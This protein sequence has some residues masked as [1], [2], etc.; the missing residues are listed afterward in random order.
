MTSRWEIIIPDLD[1]DEFVTMLHDVEL[2][3]ERLTY[4][5]NGYQRIW[6]ICYVSDEFKVMA[7]LRFQIQEMPAYG[8]EVTFRPVVD[9]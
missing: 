7:K 3:N 9:F 5:H 4:R 6:I 1:L 2:N 8:T